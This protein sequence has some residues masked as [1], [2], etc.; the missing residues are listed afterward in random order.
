MQPRGR[1]R[2]YLFDEAGDV[3][4]A[5]ETTAR[6]R[7]GDRVAS[8]WLPGAPRW[9]VLSALGRA[10]TVAPVRRDVS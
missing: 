9:R 8:C 5:C 2:Y 4:G 10:A 3:I 6:L 1:F 7:R